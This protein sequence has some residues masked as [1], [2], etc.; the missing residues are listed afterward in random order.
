VGFARPGL[1]PLALNMVRTS[2]VASEARAAAQAAA[3]SSAQ[4]TLSGLA[5]ALGSL[6]GNWSAS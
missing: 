2:W 4:V 3:L 1:N 5:I 6:L